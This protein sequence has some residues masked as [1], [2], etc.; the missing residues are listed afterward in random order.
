MYQIQKE[1]DDLTQGALAIIVYYTRLK[2]LCEEMN[3]LNT[4]S[5]CTC[6]CTCGAKDSMHKS[7]QDRRLIQFLTGLNKVYTVIRG[8][9]FMI[10]PFPSAGHAFSLLIQE[11]K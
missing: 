6:T 3:T 5:I 2:K 8:N 9:I 1:I 10:N 4:N 7:E 11:E